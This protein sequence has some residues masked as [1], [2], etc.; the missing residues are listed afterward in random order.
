[1]LSGYRREVVVRYIEDRIF[2]FL[3]VTLIFITGITGGAVAVNGLREGQKLELTQYLYLFFQGFKREAQPAV[4]FAPAWKIVFAH[5]KTVFL[6]FLFGFSVIGAPVILF[7]VFTKGFIL[8]FTA[9]FILKQWAG[10]GFL[11]VMTALFPH[12]I[13]IVPAVLTAAVVNIDFAGVLLKGRWGKKAP[14]PLTGE[15]RRCLGLNG[16][17]FLVLLIAGLVEGVLSPFL[18]YWVAQLF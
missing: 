10:R 14:Y 17:S 2:I 5:L 8:G 6:L 7:I 12:H 16:V 4:D 15:L 13:L 9:G 3:L 11:F 18:I 1:M